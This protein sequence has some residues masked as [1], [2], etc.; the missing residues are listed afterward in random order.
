ME[1]FKPLV[2]VAGKFEKLT[3][4]IAP[5]GDTISVSVLPG[6]NNKDVNEKLVPVVM[7]GTAQELDDEFLLHIKQ[8]VAKVNGLTTNISEFEKK[9]DEAA[10]ELKK[11]GETKT[12]K[13]PVAKKE[14]PKAG[15]KPVAKKAAKEEVVEEEEETEEENAQNALDF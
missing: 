14:T 4:I 2:E 8:A 3:L 15:K 10:E 1:F 13:K 11:E 9:L 12:A 5:V 7:T 6:T